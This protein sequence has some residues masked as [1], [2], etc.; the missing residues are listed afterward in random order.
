MARKR[1]GSEDERLDDSTIERVITYLGTKGATKKNACN[2]L[3][4]AYNTTR[5]DKIIEQ[6]K[7][8]KE[9]EAKRRA[10]KRGKPATKEEVAFVISEYLEGNN[11]TAISKALFR[12]ITLVKN[13][14]EEYAVPERNSSPDYFHPCLI[15]DEAVRE[16]FTMGEIV[17]SARYDCLAQVETEMFQNEQYVYRVYLRGN[18]NM[19]AYQPACELASLEKLRSEGFIK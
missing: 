1:I 13:I 16:R 10:E 14:L 8:K 18:Q 4:I 15:P 5:L 12:G 11:I 17:Y 19:W 7:T 9:N 2:I 6:Y 3:N